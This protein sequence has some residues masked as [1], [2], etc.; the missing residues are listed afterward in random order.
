MMTT[1][2]TSYAV[3][4]RG[5]NVGGRRKVPMA[6]LRELLGGLG[7]EGVR[8]HLQSGNAVF[9]SA[10]EDT[11]ALRR[12]IE[13]ALL[14]RFGFEVGCVVRDAAYLRDVVD[15]CPFDADALEGR[16]LHV[17]YFSGRVGPERLSGLDPTAHLPDEFRLGDRA[18][19][20]YA[21]E[22]VGRSK[23]ADALNRPGLFGDT[24][25]T[26]RNWNT[27]VKLVELTHG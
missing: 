12:G 14:D 6:E 1:A 8:T 24:V 11:E 9:R 26:S 17:T 7:H 10:W 23:L 19:Y 15:G 21:P 22:G 4:L 3:L 16:Q 25:A 27:V 2:T 5:V 20:L 13:A 18:L